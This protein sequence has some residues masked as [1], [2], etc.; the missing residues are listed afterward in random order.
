ML[1]FYNETKNFIVFFCIIVMVIKS[2]IKLQVNS[3]VSSFT[4]CKIYFFLW[5]WNHIFLYEINIFLN[6]SSI[7]FGIFLTSVRFHNHKDFVLYWQ[8]KNDPSD[9]WPLHFRLVYYRWVSDLENML[10]VAVYLI[11]C[12]E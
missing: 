3:Q 12:L 11:T 1:Y 5:K 8:K 6:Y 9:F 2:Q 7:R 10:G 4:V